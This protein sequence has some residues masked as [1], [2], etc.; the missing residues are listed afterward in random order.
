MQHIGHRF[1]KQTEVACAEGF[2]HQHGAA[3]IMD[4]VLDRYILGQ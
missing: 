4:R 2:G 1:T 3:D